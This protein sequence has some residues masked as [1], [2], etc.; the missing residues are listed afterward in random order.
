MGKKSLLKKKVLLLVGIPLLLLLFPCCDSDE[1]VFLRNCEFR[2]TISQSQAV[3]GEEITVKLTAVNKS[4]AYY[5]E[6]FQIQ[7]QMDELDFYVVGEKYINCDGLNSGEEK[8][9]SYTIIPT[10][11]G[12]K[13]IGPSK[14]TQVKIRGKNEVFQLSSTVGFSN[15][16]ELEVKPINLSI[17]QSFREKKARLGDKITLDV[18]VTNESDIDLTGVEISFEKDAEYIKRKSHSKYQAIPAGYERKFGFS[19]RPQRAGIINASRAKIKRLRTA[20]GTWITCNE[21]YGFSKDPEPQIEISPVYLPGIDAPLTFMVRELENYFSFA[22][23]PKLLGIA[24]TILL[25]PFLFNLSIRSMLVDFLL[26]RIILTFLMMAVLA[27]F[28]VFLGEGCLWF[29]KTVL[30]PL[31]MI[32]A[33]IAGSV[34]LALISGF[35]PGKS[36]ILGSTISGLPLALVS[37]ILYIGFKAFEINDFSNFP[38]LETGFL[39]FLF[40][41]ILNA[42]FLRK[43]K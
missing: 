42:W 40:G 2:K 30:P 24:F 12:K 21:G 26:G 14:I 27:L 34:S 19:Y 33:M 36:I 9:F 37:Y 11:S 17:R 43:E 18:F 7:K 3:V 6:F 20:S 41:V 5:V 16:I 10:T 1:T 38:F 28:L 39:A 31:W 4:S 29:W 32:A 23:I 35:T 8:I 25:I 22:F 15:S 13:V